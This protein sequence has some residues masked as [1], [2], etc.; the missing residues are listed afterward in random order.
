MQSNSVILSKSYFRPVCHRTSLFKNVCIYFA[1]EALQSIATDPGLYQMLPRFSTFISEGVSTFPTSSLLNHFFTSQKSPE[2]ICVQSADLRLSSKV[3]VNVV[4]NNLALLI[5]LMRM[6]KALM[7]NPTLYLE[8]YVSDGNKYN[9]VLF[10]EACNPKHTFIVIFN[11]FFSLF[12][13]IYSSMSSS[14]LW[15]PVLWVSSCVCDR[16][17]TTTGL[18][19]TLLL[20]LWPKVV[21][22]SVQQPTT[23]SLVLPRLLPR[24][25]FSLVINMLFPYWRCFDILYI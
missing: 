19:G 17:L 22:P 16:M 13:S 8:K 25:S 1:Q 2:H 24:W 18:Y 12:L 5:Y 9:V 21:K 20:V 6:V 23:F 14:R 4:Q 7:D 11:F 15:S 3:R 10:Y